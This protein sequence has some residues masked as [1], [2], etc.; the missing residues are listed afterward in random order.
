MV[1]QKVIDMKPQP[2]DRRLIKV[3]RHCTRQV[4]N[5]CSYH[6][7]G[8]SILQMDKTQAYKSTEQYEI[9]LSFKST[10]LET[11]H[12]AIVQNHQKM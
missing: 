10:C 12:K 11:F 1:G 7:I 6:F 8:S 5:E 4:T 9:Q 2:K 3:S